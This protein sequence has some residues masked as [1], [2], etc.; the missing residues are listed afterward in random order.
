MTIYNLHSQLYL[1]TALIEYLTVLLGYLDLLQT[2]GRAQQT[3][4]RGWALPGM[5]FGYITV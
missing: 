4:G 1:V 5:P 2:G 3:I